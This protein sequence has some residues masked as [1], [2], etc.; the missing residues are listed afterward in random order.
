MTEDVKKEQ[1]ALLKFEK[2][3]IGLATLFAASAPV[4]ASAAEK[5]G[6]HLSFAAYD[7]I[8]DALVKLAE[9][10]SAAHETMESA[11]TEAGVGFIQAAGLPK[12]PPPV[13]VV[14]SLLGIG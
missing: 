7:G 1:V 3:L 10:T 6:N 4:A 2:K 5:T 8:S 13:E 14:K 12:S 11:A 9:A